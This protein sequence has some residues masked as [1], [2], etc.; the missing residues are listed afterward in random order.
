MLYISYHL[1][2]LRQQCVQKPLHHLEV[3]NQ[4]NK[5]L[6]K[7]YSSTMTNRPS[8]LI[9]VL[10]FITSQSVYLNQVNG[11]IALRCLRLQVLHQNKM[12]WEKPDS[13]SAL[14]SIAKGHA[15]IC[16]DI[17]STPSNSILVQSHVLE[18]FRSGVDTSLVWSILGIEKSCHAPAIHPLHTFFKLRVCTSMG[19]WTPSPYC[20]AAVIYPWHKVMPWKPSG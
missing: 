3:I 14:S 15:Y 4:V 16:V 19:R 18:L 2:G 13:L 9:L 11:L 5:L 20:Q 8:C 17:H 12:V 7:F 10:V 6:S 1:Q